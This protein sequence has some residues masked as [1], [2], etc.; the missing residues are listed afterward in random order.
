MITFLEV[1]LSFC[2]SEQIQTVFFPLKNV[3]LK[4]LVPFSRMRI[5]IFTESHYRG[6]REGI[7]NLRLGAD[8]QVTFN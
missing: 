7:C 3:L 8:L 1:L 4:A 5:F 6:P 2:I